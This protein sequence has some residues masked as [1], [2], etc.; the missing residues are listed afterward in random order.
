M[1]RPRIR[2]TP[3]QQSGLLLHRTRHL[4]I[5]QQTAVVNARLRKLGFDPTAKLVRGQSAE[6]IGLLRL[7]DLRRSADPR[8]LFGKIGFLRLR[9]AH[10][11]ARP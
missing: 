10:E 6:E 3:E 4:F 8:D 11:W 7:K 1:V 9:L 5:R 2:C